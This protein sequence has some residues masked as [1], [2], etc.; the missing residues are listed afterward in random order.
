MYATDK[1]GNTPLHYAAKNYHKTTGTELA[2]LL[3]EFGD[4]RPDAVNNEGKTALEIA[5]E[6]NNEP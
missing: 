1:N 4:P 6:A 2:G 3:F 5:T